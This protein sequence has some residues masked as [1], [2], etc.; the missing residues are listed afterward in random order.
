MYNNTYCPNCKELLIERNGY[1]TKV[2]MKNNKCKKCGEII[3]I[4]I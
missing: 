2:F 1:H 4:A 3:N